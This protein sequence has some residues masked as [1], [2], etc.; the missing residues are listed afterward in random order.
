MAINVNN[1]QKLISVI[2]PCYNEAGNIRPYCDEVSEVMNEYRDYRYEIIVV[3]DGSAD[4][5]NEILHGLTMDNT[6]VRGVYLV[7]NF[8]QQA[9]LLAGIRDAKADAVITMDIDGQHPAD[10][11]GRLIGKWENG[12]QVVYAV[13]ANRTQGRLKKGMS[14]AYYR[15]LTFLDAR[16]AGVPVNDFRLMDRRVADM[17]LTLPAQNLYL[18]GILA[19][20]F[21]VCNSRYTGI[22][23]YKMR[24]RRS[25]QTKFSWRKMLTL[26][27][28]GIT[29]G[30]TRPLWLA[31]CFSG[32][33]I[34]IALLLSAQA[35]YV[36]FVGQSTVPGWTSLTIVILFFSSVQFLILGIIGEYV[37]K[38]YQVVQGTPVF[39]DCDFGNQKH[40]L[41]HKPQI[42]NT[43][44]I[45]N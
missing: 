19:S 7:R 25:G 12:A 3:D 40:N 32:V 36:Y 1:Q 9:A 20:S 24:D 15:L 4:D 33:T 6:G 23:E 21:P 10:T 38:V 28:S 34:G 13:A 29:S 17:I 41:K 42:S 26:A 5:S 27:I 31:V 39:V 8:G 35:L 11:I 45:K 18:R 14:R 16:D 43:V 2:T 22:I 30:S 44:L 37:G